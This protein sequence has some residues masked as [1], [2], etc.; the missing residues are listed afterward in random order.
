[1]ILEG[2]AK[3]LDLLLVIW[4]MAKEWDVYVEQG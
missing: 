2:S 4:I 3:A 1:M